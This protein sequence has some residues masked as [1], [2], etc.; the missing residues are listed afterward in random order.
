M[1]TRNNIMILDTE[2]VGTFGQPLIHDLGYVIVD[3]NFNVLRKDRF[4]VKELHILGKWILKTSDFYQEYAKDY[5]TARKEEKIL[6]WSEIAS[7]MVKVIRQY[8]VTT[9]SAY[10]LQFDYKAIKYT[11]ELFNNSKRQ[12][13]KTLDLKSKALL[14]IYHL[15]CETILDTDEY[16]NFCEE[17]GYISEKGNY[18]T[19]AECAYRYITKNTEYDEKHTALSD[20]MDEKEILEYICKNTKQKKLEYG[21]FYNC[22]RKVQ[23]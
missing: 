8:K 4:L 18:K 6:A 2:T 16:R 7:E 20:S 21:L 11:E 13:A 14:C 23:R 19:S 15:A 3:K 9:I 22:W 5:Y 17:N 12:F 10:N 1:K